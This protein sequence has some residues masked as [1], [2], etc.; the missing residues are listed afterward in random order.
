VSFLSRSVADRARLRQEPLSWLCQQA[1]TLVSG[2]NQ[3]I[4]LIAQIL[5]LFVHLFIPDHKDLDYLC[6]LGVVQLV[7]RPHS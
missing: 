7:L 5:R 6:N 2:Y 3:S 1:D 4:A